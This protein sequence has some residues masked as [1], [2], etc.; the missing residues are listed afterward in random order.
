MTSIKATRR[1][2]NLVCQQC[3]GRWDMKV[4]TGDLPGGIRVKCQ[5]CEELAVHM[6]HR[7]HPDEPYVTTDDDGEWCGEVPAEYE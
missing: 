5:Q 1:L 4:A 6:A 7:L 3:G 2:H